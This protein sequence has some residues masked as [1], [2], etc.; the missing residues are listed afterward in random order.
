[1]VLVWN[2]NAVSVISNPVA[3][4]PPTLPGLGQAPPLAALSLGMV[5]GAVYDAVNAIDKGHEPYLD[6]LSAPSSAS[7]AAAVAQA[8]HD[9]LLGLVAAPPA[10]AVARADALLGDSLAL[11]DDGQA[12]TDGI[13]IGHS[14][15]AA[16]L[17]A[18]AN[19]GR[20]DVEPFVPGDDPGEWVPVPPLNGNAFGQFATVTPSP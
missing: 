20:F 19:D 12:K 9:V 16:M 11:I 15:A 7:K 14:A 8:A 1:M 10:A 18:R 3:P 5:Q 4:V 6:G 2:E 13:A 17:A